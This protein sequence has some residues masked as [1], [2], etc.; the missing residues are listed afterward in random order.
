MLTFD[1]SSHRYRWN[2]EPVP[3]VTSVL[4]PLV[5][6]NKVPWQTLE[7]ARQEGVAIHKTIELYLLC[8][9]DEN[10]LPD[11]LRPRLDAFKRFE[12]ESGFGATSP[13][14]RVFHPAHQY[15]GTLD[16]VGM[17]N[18]ERCIIDIKRSLFAGPVIGLQTA[19][20]QEAAN[21][22][23]SRKGAS[24]IK[25]RYALLLNANGKYK[26]QEYD[27]KNDFA[28]FLAMLTTKRWRETHERSD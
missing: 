18:G 13:E 15:A 12:R 21:A 7:R 28:V 2:G 5:N 11:W 8:D 25:R 22:Q 17:M 16:A 14:Q 1:E 26:L 27:D 19:A 4:A 10:T 23:H 24:R 3:N 6:Y 9:L 20:Y